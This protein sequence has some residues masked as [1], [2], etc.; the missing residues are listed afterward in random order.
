MKLTFKEYLK[1]SS[2]IIISTSMILDDKKIQEAI[3]IIGSALSK[4]KP[5][6]ICGNGGSA[7]DSMHIAGELVG[8]FLK[9]RR[10]L[11]CV[12]LAANS[13]ILTAWSNDYDYETVYSRQVEALAQENGVVWGISTSGNSQN[14]ILALQKAKELGMKTVGLTGSGGGKMANCSDILLDVPSES[15]PLIQQVHVCIYHY[16]CQAVEE[17]IANESIRNYPPMMP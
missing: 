6:L 13:A 7:A 12:S 4:N 9:E 3:K 14:I 15:T 2:E 16:I 1:T 17:F 11:N 5:L 10:A 8:R